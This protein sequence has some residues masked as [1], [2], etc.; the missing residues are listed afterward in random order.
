MMIHTI[1][2]KAANRLANAINT[3]RMISKTAMRV[4]MR[5]DG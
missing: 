5:G 4:F 1:A 2:T 3:T